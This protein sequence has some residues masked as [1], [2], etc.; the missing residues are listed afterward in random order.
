MRIAYPAAFCNARDRKHRSVRS[1][2]RSAGIM[3]VMEAE[4]AFCRCGNGL[5]SIKCSEWFAPARK[6]L[7]MPAR[8]DHGAEYKVQNVGF[9]SVIIAFQQNRPLSPIYFDDSECCSLYA[10]SIRTGNSF[11]P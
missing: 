8:K 7:S 9:R 11:G 1:G 4:R 6:D 3:T 10:K 5:N 2:R